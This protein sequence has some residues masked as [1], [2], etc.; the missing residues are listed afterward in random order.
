MDRVNGVPSG[1]AL[2]VVPETD[3][4]VGWESSVVAV[5]TG[6][7]TELVEVGADSKDEFKANA[8]FKSVQAAIGRLQDDNDFVRK[9]ELITAVRLAKNA[10]DLRAAWLALGKSHVTRFERVS[11]GLDAETVADARSFVLSDAPEVGVISRN[12]LLADV[13][14][15]VL[16]MGVMRGGAKGELADIGDRVAGHAS[17]EESAGFLKHLRDLSSASNGV[18][19]PFEFIGTTLLANYVCLSVIEAVGTDKFG[20][21]IKAAADA[22][23]TIL[24]KRWCAKVRFNRFD[25]ADEDALRMKEVREEAKR[26]FMVAKKDDDGGDADILRELRKIGRRPAPREPD[27]VQG[28]VQ[29]KVQGTVQGKENEDARG[30]FWSG[31]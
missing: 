13:V 4:Y 29:G 2:G 19:R 6:G 21:G 25:A 23:V 28:A 15:V 27:E 31:V 18:L 3:A 5:G 16:R 7:G 22:I 1:M 11:K 30:M 9:D 12:F 20:P 8:E 26:R 14:P 10:A 17:S 24:V